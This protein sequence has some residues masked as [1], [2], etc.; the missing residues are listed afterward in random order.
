MVY[1]EFNPQ[2]FRF[3]SEGNSLRDQISHYTG[4]PR[5][6]PADDMI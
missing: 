3:T 5:K 4:K 2:W 1:I 6:L